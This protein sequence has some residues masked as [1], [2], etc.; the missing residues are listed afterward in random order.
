MLAA[1]L[2]IVNLYA[3][4]AKDAY[5]YIGDSVKVCGRV[6]EIFRHN[7]GHLFLN[8]DGK[9]PHQKITFVIWNK[10]TK[11]FKGIH[12]RN[13]Y[14]CAKGLIREYRGGLQIFLKTRS[15][16]SFK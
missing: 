15:Q 7:N 10:F 11:N 1:F 6:E 16:L 4:S 14:I 8:I 13:R 12:F 9:Y 5:K 3:I 2:V